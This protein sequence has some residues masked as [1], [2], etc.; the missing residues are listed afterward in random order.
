MQVEI[1]IQAHTEELMAYTA[2]ADFTKRGTA[3]GA[4]A[5]AMH[6]Y[7][8]LHVGFAVL[9][10]LAGIDKFFDWMTNWDKYLAPAVTSTLGVSSHTF[11]SIVGGIEIVAGLLVA[12]KPRIGAYVVAAWLVGII[13]NLAINPVHYWDVAARDFG[14]F[15]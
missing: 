12:L 9:P 6:A 11:M 7:S 4:D 3:S 8:I 2:P 5:G 13:A 14:L 15:L 1:H 10:I